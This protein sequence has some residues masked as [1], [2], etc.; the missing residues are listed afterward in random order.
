M[1]KGLGKEKRE[2]IHR[3]YGGR[4]SYCGEKV[5]YSKMH[6]DHIT[7]LYRGW[8]KYELEQYGKVKG[9]GK[10]Y[11]LTPSCATCNISKSTFSVDEWR[12]ELSLK[13]DRLRNTAVNFR[14]MEKHKLVKVINKPVV[15]YFEK[16][17]FDNKSNLF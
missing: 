14:L 16:F 17:D 4:C 1:P 9:S 13:I 6:V 10:M 8:S 12:K 11:N 3:K 15:F 7:P 2:K 5:E